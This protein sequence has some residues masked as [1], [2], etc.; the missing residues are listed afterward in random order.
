MTRLLNFLLLATALLLVQGC[1]SSKTPDRRTQGTFIEDGTIA[2]TAASRIRQK[3]ADKVHVNVNSYNRKVLVSGEVANEIT[4]A[5]IFRIVGGVQNVTDIYNELNVA[6]LS[7]LAARSADGATTS[8]VNLRLKESGGNFSA[9]VV[10]VVTEAGAV[11]LL[12]L[13]THAEGNTATE[14]ARTSNGAKRV[15]PLFQYID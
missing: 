14:I 6:P 11:Y 10:K 8:N 2:E 7:T 13:V 9:E 1:A 12:G 3:F 5:E 4:K 15:I